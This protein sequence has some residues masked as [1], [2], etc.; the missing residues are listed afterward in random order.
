M[1]PQRWYWHTQRAG[2]AIS[3]V[4][5]ARRRTRG[6]GVF[7]RCEPHGRPRSSRDVNCAGRYRL[8]PLPRATLRSL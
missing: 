6:K 7:S 2:A 1:P 4:V 8:D 5:T 3:I